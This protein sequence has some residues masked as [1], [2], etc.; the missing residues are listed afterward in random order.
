MPILRIDQVTLQRVELIKLVEE[1]ETKHNPKRFRSFS[2]LPFS[3]TG[4]PFTTQIVGGTRVMVRAV[5]DGVE[6]DGG[7]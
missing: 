3:T 5:S 2:W 4:R 1:K 6:R 7:M